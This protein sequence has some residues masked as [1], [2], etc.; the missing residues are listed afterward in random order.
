MTARTT[1]RSRTTHPR[2]AAM[3]LALVI[4]SLATACVRK[5][6]WPAGGA[7]GVG[8][9]R[10]SG[11]DTGYAVI[12]RPEHVATTLATRLR[13]D[14][15]Q[16]ADAYV[17]APDDFLQFVRARGWVGQDRPRQCDDD[18]GCN[19]P[20]PSKKTWM[21]VQAIDDSHLI[22]LTKLGPNGTLVGRMMNIGLHRDARYHIP[23]YQVGEYTVENYILVLPPNGKQR[24]VSLSFPNGKP[25]VRITDLD[26][27]FHPCPPHD[28]PP[29]GYA[30]ADFR[31]CP[32]QTKV[33]AATADY[34]TALA[35]ISCS[36]GCCSS[37]FPFLTDA[38]VRALFGS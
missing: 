33:A 18:A 36:Y 1:L 9:A 8:R 6:E 35:W 23:A 4:L 37:E 7:A 34:E 21:R 5:P 25:R 15:P 17:G 12:N 22:D 14:L 16:P 24:L 29:L 31:T 32:G 27:L 38:Q 2:R 30:F 10:E 20:T 26:G 3:Q 28:D 13:G 19:G 11:P